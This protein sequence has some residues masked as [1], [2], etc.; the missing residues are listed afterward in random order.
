MSSV[1]HIMTGAIDKIRQLALGIIAV[2]SLSV[3]SVAACACSH[4]QPSP[5]PAKSCHGPTHGESNSN[6][7]A[8]PNVGESCVCVQPAPD[9]SVKSE[10]FKFKKHTPGFIDGP[11]IEPAEFRL[12]RIAS[13]VDSP[14]SV[15]SSEL[16]ASVF[17]RG[18][19]V[20]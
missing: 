10:S 5:Q 14:Q 7:L 9:R 16:S 1:L 2:L 20:Y 17:S 8:L 18:P 4:H 15:Y 6:G 11:T 19:P 12:S 3:S 13:S